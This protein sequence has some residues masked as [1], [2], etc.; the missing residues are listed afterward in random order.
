MNDAD[1]FQTT[2]LRRLRRTVTSGDGTAYEETVLQQR[3]VPV[4][5]ITDLE[6]E[7][8]DVPIVTEGEDD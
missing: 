1:Y 6:P 2:Q 4:A 5:A 3:W 8:R 7:W